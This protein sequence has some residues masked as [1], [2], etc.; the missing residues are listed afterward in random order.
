MRLV[1]VLVVFFA[2]AGAQPGFAQSNDEVELTRAVISAKKKLLVAQNMGLTEQES[3]RFWPIYEDYQQALSKVDARE[4]VLLTEYAKAYDHL[5]N[6]V[7]KRLLKEALAIDQD[8]LSLQ[9]E[10]LERFATVLSPK[11]VARYYQIEHKLYAV[12]SYELA[13]VIP[14]VK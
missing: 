1:V 11:Q 4:T 9:R 3:A 10:Y 13:K 12:V 2:S 6:E 5:S 8:R 14:L 7:A